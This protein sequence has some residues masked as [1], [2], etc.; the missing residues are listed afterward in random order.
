MKD[1]YERLVLEV[2]KSFKRRLKVLAAEID[3]GMKEYIII[4]VDEKD[5]NDLE[6]MM[7]EVK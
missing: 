6:K 1:D 4:A 5:R 2:P 3:C 7:R